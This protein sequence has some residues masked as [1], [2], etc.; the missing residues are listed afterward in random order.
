ME[1]KHCLIAISLVFMI[2]IL[3]PHSSTSEEDSIKITLFSFLQKLSGN[4][5]KF[6]QQLGWDISSNPC[7]GGWVGVSCDDNSSSVTTITLNGLGLSGIIDAGIICKAQSLVFLSLSNNSLRGELPA[8]ISNCS[9]LI[10]LNVSHNELSGNLPSS[11]S[12]L[13]DLRSIDVSNNNFSGE[14]P[15]QLLKIS[16]LESLLV[17]NNQFIGSIPVFNFGFLKQFNVSYNNFSGPIPDGNRFGN[18]SFLGNSGLCGTPLRIACPA[19]APPVEQPKK[20][21]PSRLQILMYSGYILLV[22][23]ILLLV[24]FVLILK[25]KKRKKKIK[26]IKMGESKKMVLSTTSQNNT[27]SFS[28]GYRASNRSDNYSIASSVDRGGAM[29]SSESLVILK[30]PVNA[31][32]RFDDLLKAP[33]E[34]MGKGMYGSL[35]R[36]MVGDGTKLVVKR[37][38]EWMISDEEFQK[39]MEN[40]DKVRHPKVLSAVAFYCSKQ[41]KLVVYE[42]QQNGSLFKLLQDA[43]RGKSFDWS[44]RLNIAVGIAEGLSFMHNKL[45]DHGIPHGNLKSTNILLNKNMEPCISEYGL[46]ATDNRNHPSPNKVNKDKDMRTLKTDVYSFGMLLLELLTG[47]LVQDNGIELTKWVNNVVREEWTVEVFDRA[48]LAEYESQESMV[49]LLQVAL[50]CVNTYPDVRPTMSQVFAMVNSIKEEE[51]ERSLASEF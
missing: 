15:E 33:A 50:K 23:A 32:L 26:E 38:M 25:N 44:S 5:V 47:K 39:R 17:D 48:L 24:V 27:T 2:L 11:L 8:E 51:E 31:G 21:M 36:V 45:Q 40:I 10:H 46:M 7:A 22:F 13:K 42:Y 43:Q 14:L 16:G 1:V 49:H 3:L 37:I 29:A 35:Y 18:D 41:E 9:E 4:A 12:V 30:S 19:A 34:P 6:S 20:K 28:N